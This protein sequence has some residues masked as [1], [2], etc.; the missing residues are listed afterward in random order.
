M[1]GVGSAAAGGGSAGAAGAADCDT[2]AC[3][4]A[5]VSVDCA[6]IS[7]CCGSFPPVVALPELSCLATLLAEEAAPV[8][9]PSCAGAIAT[10]KIPAIAIIALYWKRLFIGFSTSLILGV[11]D[12]RE[13]PFACADP[14]P[15]LATK[16][17][18]VQRILLLDRIKSLFLKTNIYRADK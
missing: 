12:D 4:A 2:A 11:K 15:K 17:V 8:L 16:S 5:A 14:H 18:A 9:V 13:S 6:T 10:D 1:A 7:G 3:G